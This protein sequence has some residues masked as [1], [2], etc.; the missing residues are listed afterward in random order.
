MMAPT[1]LALLSREGAARGLDAEMR[2]SR[3]ADERVAAVDVPLRAAE[4]AAEPAPVVEARP[5]PS[6]WLVPALAF[7]ALVLGGY[8]LLS[9]AGGR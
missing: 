5:H 8:W 3:L 1:V 7:L 9:A 2:A 6:R 4:P